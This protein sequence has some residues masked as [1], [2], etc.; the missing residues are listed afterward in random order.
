ME[1]FLLIFLILFPMAA[2]FAVRPLRNR[3]RQGRNL[4]IQIVP[5][6]E[7]AAALCLLLVPGAS[8]TLPHV[9]GMGLT[10][11]AAPCRRCWRWYRPCCGAPPAW[12]AHPIL[13]LQ[14]GAAGITFSGC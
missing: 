3:S 1:R 2:A 4:W 14:R 8:V 6:V 12:Q 5:A 13:P 7:L 10:L 9:C 11:E